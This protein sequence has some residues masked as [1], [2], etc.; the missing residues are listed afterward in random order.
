ML[1]RT[2]KGIRNTIFAL[3]MYVVNIV[4]QFISRKIFIDK[5]GAEVLGLNTTATSLLSFLNLAELGIGTAVM[6][7]LYAPLNAKDEKS[8]REV[9]SVHGWLYKKVAVAVIALSA[10]LSLFFPLIFQKTD[11]PLWYSYASFSVI[12]FSSLIS[13]FMNYREV[14]L[15]ADQAEYKIQYSYKFVML[16]K[17]LAQMLAVSFMTNGYVWWLVLEGVFAILASIALNKTIDRSYPYL[18]N[19]RRCDREMR[20]RHKDVIDKIK[21]VFV[22][23]IGAFAVNQAIPLMVYACANLTLVTIYGNYMVI[24]GGVGTVLFAIFNSLGAGVGNLIAEGDTQHIVSVYRELFSVRFFFVST[25][26]IILFFVITP[27]V[28]VWIGGDYL[29]DKS[30]VILI[31]LIFFLNQM[32]TI[33]D[34]FL[35][36]YGMFQDIWAPIVESIIDIALGLILGHFFGLF[37]ILSG[38]LCGT[39]V[40]HFVWKPIFLYSQGFHKG[41]VGYFVMYLKYLAIFSVSTYL[42]ILLLEKYPFDVEMTWRSTIKYIIR[43]LFIFGS[44]ELSLFFI[45]DSSFRKFC[46]RVLCLGKCIMK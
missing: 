19:I 9:I 23:K 1:N 24:I 29:I 12:L 43:V 11:L 42:G 20:I 31:I 46:K 10:V 5:L 17:I 41:L 34:I 21:Q 26:C 39:F 27:F 14:V 13:Y 35:Y 3:V 4:F 32:R 44:F 30:S 6:C 38:V 25:I 2:Q 7:T 18:K 16:I 37:G 45:I 22:H 36:G 8:V 28:N 33:N 40:I 15:S